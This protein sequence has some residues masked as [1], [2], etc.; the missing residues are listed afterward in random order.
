MF[1][2]QWLSRGPCN[3]VVRPR[4]QHRLGWAAFVAAEK[5]G[6]V[7][8]VFGP[9]GAPPSGQAASVGAGVGD[10]RVGFGIWSL[11]TKVD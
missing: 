5:P 3:K 7:W 11:L 9:S 2:S 4:A 1:S 6:P 10:I 8:R